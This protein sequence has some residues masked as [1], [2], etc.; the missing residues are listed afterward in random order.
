[1][2]VAK[3]VVL[4]LYETYKVW[5][6]IN[7]DKRDG[8]F[9]LCWLITEASCDNTLIKRQARD[10]LDLYPHNFMFTRQTENRLQ[11]HFQLQYNRTHMYSTTHHH[12]RTGFLSLKIW[13]ISWGACSTQT[14]TDMKNTDILTDH[15]HATEIKVWWIC[16]AC[17]MWST[18]S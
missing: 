6:E 4:P 17:G 12:L 18:A 11:F 9:W 3:G 1:M 16:N 5:S 15:L 7:K 8:S 13:Q 14:H 10:K 2:D